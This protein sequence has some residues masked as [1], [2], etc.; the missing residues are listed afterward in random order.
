ML[1]L[2]KNNDRCNAQQEVS[3]DQLKSDETVLLFCFTYSA[4]L[5]VN[6]NSDVLMKI[7]KLKIIRFVE[8]L[9]GIPQISDLCLATISLFSKL[10]L[11]FLFCYREI[12]VSREL[13][14]NKRETRINYT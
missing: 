13:K 2:Q 7:R 12:V 3:V 11:F 4:S 14:R 10:L 1:V 6:C 5:F 9:L 8:D